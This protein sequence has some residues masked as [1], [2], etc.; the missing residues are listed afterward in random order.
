MIIDHILT[1]FQRRLWGSQLIRYLKK[2]KLL[3]TMQTIL[4]WTL[5]V[6]HT[7]LYFCQLY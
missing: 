4:I 5:L 3:Q 1:T 2:L 6:S 7:K